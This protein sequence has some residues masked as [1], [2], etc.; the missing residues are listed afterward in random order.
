MQ[1]VCEC[2]GG[3][4]NKVGGFKYI[5]NSA[6]KGEGSHGKD[7]TGYLQALSRYGRK[8][9]RINGMDDAD[10][11]FVRKYLDPKLMDIFHYPYHDEV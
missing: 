11:K 7:R 5:T 3:E 8:A 2:A 6:K 10:L 4:L 9:G 1:T